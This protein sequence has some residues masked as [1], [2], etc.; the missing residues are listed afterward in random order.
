MMQSEKGSATVSVALFGVSPNSWCGR[1][2]SPFREQARVLPTRRRD[3]DGNGRDDRAPH[4][5]LHRSGLDRTTLG[6]ASVYQRLANETGF[7]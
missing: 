3:A 2:E 5:Q 7:V 6:R 4:L 1:F